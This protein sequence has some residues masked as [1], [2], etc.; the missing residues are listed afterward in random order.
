MSTVETIAAVITGVMFLVVGAGAVAG[1]S[2][3]TQGDRAVPRSFAVF[4]WAVGAGLMLLGGGFIFA[5]AG[6][7]S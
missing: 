6:A 5:V 7:P 1:A 3:A 4:I 2:R